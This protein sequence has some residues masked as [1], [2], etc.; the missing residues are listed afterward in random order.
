MWA[1][2]EKMAAGAARARATRDAEL[3][4]LMR[5]WAREGTLK[6]KPTTTKPAAKPPT[7]K[8]A[9]AAKPAKP[10]TTKPTRPAMA[11]KPT[12]PAKP[13]RVA[14]CLGL[15]TSS[16]GQRPWPGWRS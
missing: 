13:L 10:T 4:R 11:A 1:E 8:P 6:Q 3:A 5:K 16:R 9:K 7:T 2:S 12:K 14:T 15:A